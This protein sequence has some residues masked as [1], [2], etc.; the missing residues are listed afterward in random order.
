MKIISIITEKGGVGKTT[1]S[2]HLGAAFSERGK[3]VLLIDFDEQRNLSKGYKIEK[4]FPY[5]IKNFMDKTGDFRLTQRGENLYILSGS[6]EISAE[7][8]QRTDLRERLN[9]LNSKFPFDLVIID[10]PPSPLNGK[11]KLGEIA[12][13]SSDLVIS[14]IEPE[15]YSVDG[16]NELLPQIVR[17]KKDF[18]PGLNLLGFFFNRVNVRNRR[19]KT[20]SPLAQQ[21]GKGYFFSSM[22]RIDESVETA[23]TAG[24]TVFQI[25]PK[26]RASE[27]YKNLANEIIE[28]IF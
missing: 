27:D 16:I 17:I 19:F 21:E 13:C 9:Y 15:E 24:K 20:F 12:L 2:I 6:R 7:D 26:S 4:T 22:V 25:A 28:K 1:T 14:P 11:M 5:N 8:Y 23:K 3:K 10:C 18:N